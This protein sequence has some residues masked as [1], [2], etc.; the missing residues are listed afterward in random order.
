MPAFLC[1]ETF[2]TALVKLFLQLNLTA[3]EPPALSHPC[4]CELKPRTTPGRRVDYLGHGWP[5][6]LQPARDVV[7]AIAAQFSTR[8]SFIRREVQHGDHV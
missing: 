4:M 8:G 7:A 1:V 5:P 2:G 6:R 3:T